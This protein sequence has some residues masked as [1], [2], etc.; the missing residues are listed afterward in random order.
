MPPWYPKWW[1][2]AAKSG[3]KRWLLRP[4]PTSCHE[5]LLVHW[6]MRPAQQHSEMTN[7]SRMKTYR[8]LNATTLSIDTGPIQHVMVALDTEAAECA[9]QAPEWHPAAGHRLVDFSDALFVHDWHMKC[10][11][12]STWPYSRRIKA[13]A[14]VS[15]RS[16][17]GLLT[18]F[19][20]NYF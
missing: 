8:V 11:F 2:T 4:H 9:V 7:M 19:R 6:Q 5:D 20:K 3:L 14:C 1:T 13:K 12:N 10:R 16:S 18:E 15:I 17:N